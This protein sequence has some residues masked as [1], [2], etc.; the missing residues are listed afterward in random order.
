MKRR[1]F[2][3]SS[4]QAVALLSPVLG[5]LSPVLGLLSPVVVAGLPPPLVV[6]SMGLNTII[7]SLEPLLQPRARTHESKQAF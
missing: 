7:S 6:P 2:V 5:L 3:F 1:D 4:L